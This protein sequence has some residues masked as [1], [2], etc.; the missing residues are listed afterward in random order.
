MP[1][2][3]KDWNRTSKSCELKL[4]CLDHH[5]C[6]ILFTWQLTHSNCRLAHLPCHAGVMPHV[7]SERDYCM[8][9][10]LGEGNSWNGS[11]QRCQV[12]RHRDSKTCLAALQQTSGPHPCGEPGIDTAHVQNQ[13]PGTDSNSRT[14]PDSKVEDGRKPIHR[15]SNAAVSVDWSS[16]WPPNIAKQSARAGVSALSRDSSY[17]AA[18]PPQ[19]PACHAILHA[20][21]VKR[22]G[23][24]CTRLA[25]AIG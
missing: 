7:E 6:M 10:P 20:A 5:A 22:Q 12:R 18:G 3:S 4:Q 11:G 1:A 19:Q 21:K 9:C 17:H 25:Q 23:I 14:G 24:R 15:R 2:H 13:S 8:R 16:Y